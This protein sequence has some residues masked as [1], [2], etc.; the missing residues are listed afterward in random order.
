MKTRVCLLLFSALILVKAEGTPDGQTPSEESFCNNYKNVKGQLFGFCNSYCEAMDC[1]TE[2]PEVDIVSC[3][4]VGRLFVAA[5]ASAY[6]VD[7]ADL[8][9]VYLCSNIPGPGCEKNRLPGGCAD[10][11]SDK[12]TVTLKSNRDVPGNVYGQ[13]S[14]QP[15]PYPKEWIEVPYGLTAERTMYTC[16]AAGLPDYI[17]ESNPDVFIH[18][19]RH[20]YWGGREF[21][22]HHAI[23]YEVPTTDPEFASIKAN[24]EMLNCWTP[25]RDSNGVSR[26]ILYLWQPSTGPNFTMPGNVR[27]RVGAGSQMIIQFH[28]HSP[29]WSPAGR[30]DPLFFDV[31]L[32]IG[33]A[34]DFVPGA[35]LVSGAFPH[36][37]VIGPAIDPQ[38]KKRSPSADDGS[39]SIATRSGHNHGG[40]GGHVAHPWGILSE[41]VSS[42]A[43]PC[44]APVGAHP[45][46]NCSASL[47]FQ[48]GALSFSGVDVS[49]GLAL[50]RGGDH[51]HGWGINGSTYVARPIGGGNYDMTTLHTVQRP[52]NSQWQNVDFTLRLG[53]KIITESWYDSTRGVCDLDET[54]FAECE[55]LVGSGAEFPLC[56]EDGVWNTTNGQLVFRDCG[57]CTL[58]REPC[59][60]VPPRSGTGY[61][62]EGP[63]MIGGF[64]SDD[65]M[66]V[67]FTL[68]TPASGCNA[69]QCRVRTIRAFAGDF[70]RIGSHK[71]INTH[72]PVYE[73]AVWGYDNFAGITPSPA[74]P[75]SPAVLYAKCSAFPIGGAGIHDPTDIRCAEGGCLVSTFNTCLGTWCASNGGSPACFGNPGLPA[76]IGGCIGQAVAVLT[77][78]ATGKALTRCSAAE[79]A[80]LSAL[81]SGHC[82]APSSPL[83]PV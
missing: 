29:E 36:S 47:D 75:F 52:H 37:L 6:G 77:N 61:C 17:S 43:V 9:P 79:T 10:Y 49:Q 15:G 65:E 83:C 69:D 54:C 13:L 42:P 2:N 80:H 73:P 33:C 24:G 21:G 58:V 62:Q 7:E 44:V 64:N 35:W 8:D 50:L 12:Y 57:T 78:P 28:W 3:N 22:L 45:F 18:E 27:H 11:G 81:Q 16:P 60:N 68:Y 14:Q 55:A 74:S 30:E 31:D 53:D 46:A 34:R 51:T 20:N 48:F 40:H 41:T 4:A 1:D 66:S 39:G 32:D 76:A 38:A 70:V 25:E 59:P 26:E 67:A 71:A 19:I 56:I 23:I 5:A 82:N 72:A 63:H